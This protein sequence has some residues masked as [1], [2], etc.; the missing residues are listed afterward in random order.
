MI[1]INRALSCVRTKKSQAIFDRL[2]FMKNGLRLARCE[3]RSD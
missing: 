1:G 2:A 3:F